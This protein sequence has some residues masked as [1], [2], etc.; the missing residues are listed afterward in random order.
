MYGEDCHDKYRVVIH[1]CPYVVKDIPAKNKPD[2]RDRAFEFLM[3]VVGVD[4]TDCKVLK[5]QKQ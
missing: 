1:G 3:S 5:I 4:Y 2:A